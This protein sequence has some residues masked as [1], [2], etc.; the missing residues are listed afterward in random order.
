MAF[1]KLFLENAL[2][3]RLCNCKAVSEPLLPKVARCLLVLSSHHIGKCAAAPGKFVTG[4]P[5]LKR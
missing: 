1:P 4:D 3:V 5:D 2:I